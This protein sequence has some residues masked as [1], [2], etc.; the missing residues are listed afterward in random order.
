VSEANR[1][2][3]RNNDG[4][5]CR[6]QAEREASVFLDSELAPVDVDWAWLPV[7]WKHFACFIR[8]YGIDLKLRKNWRWL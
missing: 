2:K 1:C 3:V 4:R 5:Q 7:C 8:K 6:N